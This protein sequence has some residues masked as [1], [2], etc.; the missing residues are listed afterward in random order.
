M[1]IPNPEVSHF[2]EK[3]LRVECRRFWARGV[4]F[5]LEHSCFRSFPWDR[6]RKD[7]FPA[8][9]AVPPCQHSGRHCHGGGVQRKSCGGRGSLRPS[10]VRGDVTVNCRSGAMV[11]HGRARPVPVQAGRSLCTWPSSSAFPSFWGADIFPCCLYFLVLFIL[12]F[13]YWWFSSFLETFCVREVSQPLTNSQTVFLVCGPWRGGLTTAVPRAPLPS[14]C[15]A[16]VPV[17]ASNLRVPG[18]N[19]GRVASCPAGPCVSLHGATWR[20]GSPVLCGHIS[21]VC[22]FLP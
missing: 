3:A 5:A 6:R 8:H 20:P 14:W 18:G 17:A 22:F 11:S 13:T 10:S 16:C 15:P 12:L 9:P 2:R 4:T 19:V 7:I 1:N 21:R